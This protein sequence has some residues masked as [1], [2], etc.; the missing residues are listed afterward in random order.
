MIEYQD[1]ILWADDVV[2]DENQVTK[3]FTVTVFDSPVGQGEKKETVAIPDGLITLVRRLEKRAL[4]EDV[5]KQ[6]DLG[7]MLAGL[8]LPDY[9]RRMF[10]E[11]LKRL[12]DDEGLRLRLRLADEL[13]D[14]PWEYMYIQ[15]QHGER[16]PSSFLA[17]N[18]RISIVRH[19]AIRVPGDWFEGPDQRRLVVAM[20]TPE[21]HDKYPL[22][23]N[24]PDEQSHIKGALE[25]VV[26]LEAVFLPDYLTPPGTD[27]ASATLKDLMVAFM[28]KTDIFHFSGHGEFVGAQ[29]PAFGSTIGEGGIVL[30]DSSNQAVP[31]AAD[32]LAELIFLGKRTR[33]AVL[34]ACE[35]G[36][37]DGYNV[38]SSVVASLLKAGIPAVVAMQFTIK[39]KLAAA[40]SGMFYQS[41]VAGCTVDEAVALGR[42]A[43][44][45]EALT[46]QPDIRDWGVPVLY[47][48]SQGARV[49]TPV[50]DE[51]TRQ[52][53]QEAVGHFVKQ[54][55]GTI[56][57]T[58][59][60]LGASIGA[61][62]SSAL[63]VEQE[64]GDVKGIMI[65]AKVYRVEGGRL[66]VEQKAETVSGVMHGLTIGT[67][68][69]GPG[70]TTRSLD[71]KAVQPP[72]EDQIIKELEDQLRL[73]PGSRSGETG[74]R[75]LRS[76]NPQPPAAGPEV[77]QPGAASSE[78]TCQK[79]G[80][81]VSP[82][83]NFCE[84]CGNK[85]G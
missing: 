12:R 76:N 52:K 69:D 48:R 53:A 54:Q 3:Q 47:L 83:D 41:L 75:T 25:K 37:R 60:V 82:V 29:G 70:L 42:A 20:A 1:F 78:L 50:R 17:L 8:L 80:A 4:D 57:I 79:C 43:M 35:T 2:K 55:V 73:E 67:L 45:A 39:D 18:P 81:K 13:A 59:K 23:N 58:G 49:F 19:E 68:S 51:Q 22:L 65:G 77:P 62:S 38:W 10:A 14:F 64:A 46:S 33:L 56:D 36:R 31:I 66:T 26:G 30:A 21:P 74:K 16:T 24:L 44:R 9:A 72:S 7:E 71:R 6:M 11:S 32:K 63:T 15:D 34:G 61:M 28:E 84:N 85:L 27:I 40:F 5:N